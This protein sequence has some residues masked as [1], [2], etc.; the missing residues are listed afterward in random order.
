[1]TSKLID[2]LINKDYLTERERKEWLVIIKER[3]EVL[4][5]YQAS[6]ITLTK[7][8][9]TLYQQNEKLKKAIYIVYMKTVDLELLKDC[10]ELANGLEL[11]NSKVNFLQ[12]LVALEYELLKEVL[13]E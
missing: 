9:M 12:E 8:N 7:E 10:F 3:L 5:H 4:E 6:A 11:Y 1:M 13:G 2:R